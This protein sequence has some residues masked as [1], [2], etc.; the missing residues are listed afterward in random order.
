M[1]LVIGLGNFGKEFEKTN[2]NMGFMVI[3]AVAKEIGFNFKKN[4]CSSV[5]AEGNYNGEKVV[6]AKPT[7]FMNL[8]GIAVKSLLSKYGVD[9]RD[10]MVISDDIDL[11][12][13]KVRV[14]KFGSAGTHNGLRNIV[15]N[16]GFE[17]FPRLRIGIGRPP[18]FMDLADFVLGD[19]HL[20]DT[21][22][23]GL[24]KGHE[25]VMMFISGHTLDEIMTHVN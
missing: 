1:K 2:H 24:D 25:A 15:A 16:L 22:Q 21:L 8:S 3:D 23:K 4:I 9:K 13:G 12:R 20:D 19:C 11:E 10:I 7:T 14:K 17:D 5:V 18:E 6:L